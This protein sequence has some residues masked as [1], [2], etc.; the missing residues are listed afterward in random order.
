[1]GSFMD[2]F[3]PG[4]KGVFRAG[5]TLYFFDEINAYSV[6]E[7]LRLLQAIGS[8]FPK[9]PIQI[10]LNS[11]G[12]SVYDGLCLYDYL[13]SV[14]NPIIIIGTGLVASM[15][16]IILLAGD[17]RYLTK[18]A[19]LMVHQIATHVEGKVNDVKIDYDETKE[20][21][22]ICNEIIANKIGSSIKKIA[23]E[24]KIGD[25]Y[26]SANEALEKGYIHGVI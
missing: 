11:C 26:L 10:I 4:Q 22:K 8:E 15:A 3:M 14:K 20:L 9:E 1:M 18:N 13:E 6:S 16:V 21:E 7:A 25:K 12:G 24:I 5:C 19:R 23:S 2:E 17:E